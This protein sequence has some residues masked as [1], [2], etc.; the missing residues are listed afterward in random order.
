MCLINKVIEMKKWLRKILGIDYIRDLISK[1]NEDMQQML[2][3]NQKQ[4]E[5][6]KKQVFI[7]PPQ[8][9]CQLMLKKI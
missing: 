1:N 2:T 4:L 7:C 8:T 6:L 5:D 9:T 3:E